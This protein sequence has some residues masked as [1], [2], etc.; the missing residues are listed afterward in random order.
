MFSKY[1]QKRKVKKYITH[2][3]VNAA[4]LCLVATTYLSKISH[5][6]NCI[7]YDIPGGCDIGNRLLV[8]ATFMCL[9][10][11]LAV[12]AITHAI[13]FMLSRMSR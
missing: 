6:G 8:Y 3:I 9:V 12:Q 1:K 13:K 4:L 10:V 5:N 7:Y 2:T 11:Y